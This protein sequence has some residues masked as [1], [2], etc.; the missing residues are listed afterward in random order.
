MRS[1]AELYETAM[2]G[3]SEAFAPIV[4]RYADAVFAVA[5]ARLGDFHDAQD[6]A[7]QAFVEAFERLSGL[8]DP[9]R[10]GAW[11][12]SI[13]IHR[14]IDR[15]RGRRRFAEVEADMQ[16]DRAPAPHS[17]LERKELREQVLEAVGQLSKTLRETTTLFYVD[18]YSVD[19][20]A[21]IQEVPVG[22]VKRR[23]HD[24]REK[25]Q[26]E[27]MAM[28]ED[29]L[30]SE[31]PKEALAQEVY[32]TLRLYDRPPMTME[33]W[34]EVERRLKEIGSDGIDGFIRALKSPHSPTRRLALGMLTCTG[35][36]EDLVEELLKEATKDP[37][38]KVRQGAFH[39]LFEIAWHNEDRR[40]D[41]VPHILPALRD[42]SRKVRG[43]AWHLAHFPGF[44]EHVPLEDA[45]GAAA[46]ETSGDPLLL[47]CQRELIEAVLCVREGRENP[48]S[49]F[50]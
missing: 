26:E 49:R 43:L 4:E 15:I 40:A 10:L 18:G 22:T 44:A 35:Q 17:Q 1:D 11:L 34:E 41:L 8:R 47:E 3:G 14:A 16:P 7:Q 2:S 37:N 9:T 32:E 23:L 50:Y 21:A 27:M 19:E 45:A 30:R 38:K 5:L 24:A 39:A 48:H 12:R 28:V 20:V 31:S 13:T 25:L 33:R 29:T 46:Q 6:V 36:S 42:R